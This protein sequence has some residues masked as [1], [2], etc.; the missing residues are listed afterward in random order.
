MADSDMT[1]S[2]IITKH[3]THIYIWKDGM[4]YQMNGCSLLQLQ[5]NVIGKKDALIQVFDIDRLQQ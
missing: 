4:Q 5:L 1:K 2:A 3:Y